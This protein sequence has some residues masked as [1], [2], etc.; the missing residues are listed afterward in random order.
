MRMAS[1]PSSMVT[2]NLES[3]S[4][5]TVEWRHRDSPRVPCRKISPIQRPYCTQLGTSNPNRRSR[6]S[7]SISPPTHCSSPN[8]ASMTSPGMKR[9]VRKTRMLRR[10]RVGMTS[11]KRL[12][13][14]ALTGTPYSMGE[15]WECASEAHSQL[16]FFSLPS[17]ASDHYQSRCGPTWQLSETVPVRL[18]R[19]NL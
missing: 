16:V 5:S 3:I 15:S 14:Y 17:L 7:R 9:T 12:M 10:N 11:N 4:S 8:M 13:I 19:Y 1:R 18:H 6:V 2:G